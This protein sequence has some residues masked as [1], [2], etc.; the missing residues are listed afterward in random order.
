MSYKRTSNKIIYRN[1]GYFEDAISFNL[2]EKKRESGRS[3]KNN[4]SNKQSFQLKILLWNTA[5]LL[6][7]GNLYLICILFYILR[8][9]LYR[10]KPIKVNFSKSENKLILNT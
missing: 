9:N 7:V 6:T 2:I 10:L 3:Q 8:K 4:N 5:L 1:T